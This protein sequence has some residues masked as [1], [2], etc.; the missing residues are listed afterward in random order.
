M[1]LHWY[2]SQNHF[3]IQKFKKWV[4]NCQS[5]TIHKCKCRIIGE[6]TSSRWKIRCEE[7]WLFHLSLLWR[8]NF[9]WI[10]LT[11]HHLCKVS[12]ILIESLGRLLSRRA[13]EQVFSPRRWIFAPSLWSHPLVQETNDSGAQLHGT[14]CWGRHTN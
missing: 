7:L 6:K 4:N 8:S 2:Y 11:F 14:W 3:S 1:F 12:L 13:G 10:V 9:T 5:A